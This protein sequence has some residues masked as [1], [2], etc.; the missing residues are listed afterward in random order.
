M[1][2]CKSA[3]AKNAGQ[4][5]SRPVLRLCGKG[6]RLA[7]YLGKAALVQQG[8]PSTRMSKKRRNINMDVPIELSFK[9]VPKSDA[10]DELVREQADKLDDI[11]KGMT[12]C[13]VSIEK[14]H[15]SQRQGHPYR[16]RIIA[17]VPPGHELVVKRESSEGDMHVTLSTVIIDAFEALNRQC[18]ELNERQRH[19]VKR[20]PEQE[21]MG[22]VVR[23][24]RED[25]YG[26]IKTTEEREIYFHQNSVIHND[27]ERV[28]IGTGVRFVETQGDEGPQATTVE[29]VNKPGVRVQTDTEAPIEPPEGWQASS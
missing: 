6:T 15:Q 20:H 24:F 13:R 3:R 10:V 9:D 16:V 25:G 18:R 23:L 17:R 8:A 26:F 5:V 22:F 29:I 1:R 2:E 27:W 21:V 28:E 4:S 7:L 19:N 14:R 12:S 11:C